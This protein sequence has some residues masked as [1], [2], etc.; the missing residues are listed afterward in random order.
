[1]Y[2]LSLFSVFW[3]LYG[4][5]GL[6]LRE[7][8]VVDFNVVAH[9]AIEIVDV[10]ATE[11]LKREI[12]ASL[13]PEY[14]VDP[15]VVRSVKEEV[16]Q[17]FSSLEEIRAGVSSLSPSVREEFS[18]KWRIT[19]GTF[20]RLVFSREEEYLKIKNIFL[21]M[22]VRYLAQPIRQED[23]VRTILDVSAELE[24]IYPQE[25]E[26][27]V[28][29][30]LLYRFLKP[31]AVLDDQAMQRRRVEALQEMEPVRKIIP[32]GSILIPKGK[33]ITFE[34]LK[35]LEA[36]GF[37]GQEYLWVRLVM[38]IF[39]IGGSIAVEYFYLKRFAP[40][41]LNRNTFLGLRLIAVVGILIINGALFRFS[42]RFVVLAAIPLV[43]FAL[44]DRNLALGES[45]ILFPLLV[46]GTRVD[47]FQA[48]YIYLNLLLP[49]FLLERT[50]K[51]RDFIRVGLEL[52]LINLVLNLGFGIQR[53]DPWITN[54]EHILYGFGGGIV[55]PI[56]ALGGISFLE[57]AFRFTSDIHL[58][59]FL[60]PTHP[61]LQQLL[62]EAPGTYSH[63]LMVANLAEAASEEIGAN[64][65]LVRVGAY[66]HDIGKLK[67]PYFFVENQLRGDNIHDQLSPN[68]STLVI[69]KHV[70]DGVELAQQYKLPLEVQ[71]IIRRHHG[72]SL[73]RYFY[74]KAL[75][76]GEKVEEG[77]FR[78]EGPLPHTKEEVLVF[79]ADSVEAAMHCIDNP[80]PRR[81]E[82]MVNE[83]IDAYLRDG[84]LNEASLTLQDL[85][86]VAHKFTMIINGLFH[87]R[88]SYPELGE[89]KNGKRKNMAG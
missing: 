26:E 3:F 51:R 72:K 73:T 20:D 60:N 48:L 87:K 13:T 7:G 67:R 31:N 82:M 71:E 65:L 62:R 59:E 15:N 56:V 38:L 8:Q 11:K 54:V 61:L 40:S 29:S 12:L 35:I 27:R 66:Y 9:R 75:G 53:G 84:Q 30:L 57:T 46:W 6:A 78:Y 70:Q 33:T 43:L 88:L 1:L 23:L 77:I 21:E 45:L 49:L 41:V 25:G 44:G 22:L 85:Y 42:D 58:M 63:S 68:L 86:R 2:G 50:L 47:F 34:D 80:S 83:I 81:V 89:S 39:L 69:R 32:R 52:A 24:R 5:R 28:V 64:P 76:R 4:L 10:E 36:L 79:L 19:Q 17:F 16:N 37:L 14:Q 74:H 55:S 18:G